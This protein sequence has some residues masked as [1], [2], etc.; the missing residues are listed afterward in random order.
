MTDPQAPVT[1]LDLTDDHQ[2]E[3]LLDILNHRPPDYV[4]LGMPCGTAS[5]TRER[6]IS[7][8]QRRMGAPNP[9][10]LRSGMHPL[11]LPHVHPESTAGIRLAKA[12]KL[13]RFVI[14]ILLLAM[15]HGSLVSLE[16][17]H[18]S[19]FWAAILATILKT[20]NT[21]LVKFWDSLTDV[22]FHNCCHGGQRWKGTRWKSS[23]HVFD[24]LAAECQ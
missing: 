8:Q 10:P 20:N 19:W 6:P 18:R 9:T 4:H 13:Y 21:E 14:Q 15:R 24:S 1:L 22:F 2:Q 3:I 7:S 16:N 23:P 11:G 12:N 17:P 5:P